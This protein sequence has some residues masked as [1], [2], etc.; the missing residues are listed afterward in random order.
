MVDKLSTKFLR[1]IGEV[2]IKEWRRHLVQKL[3]MKSLPFFGTIE[4]RDKIKRAAKELG[5]EVGHGIR[6]EIPYSLQKSLKALEALSYNLKK[7]HPRIRRNIRFDDLEKDLVLDF[8]TDPDGN[9]WR[10]AAAAQ[11]IQMNSQ[12]AKGR[13]DKVTSTALMSLLE[14]S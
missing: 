12:F 1:E 13:T 14:A 5:G 10:R 8:N 3:R 11:A 7:K 6:L 2:S 4:I 9:N